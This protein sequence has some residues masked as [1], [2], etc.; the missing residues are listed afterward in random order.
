MIVS[1]KRVIFICNQILFND[2]GNFIISSVIIFDDLMF[3]ALEAVFQIKTQTL[4]SSFL[5]SND[6]LDFTFIDYSTACVDTQ[7]KS[8]HHGVH[9]L[10]KTRSWLT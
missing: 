2:Y 4:I 10:E 7:R 8:H 6:L 3:S 5:N 9:Q 1:S